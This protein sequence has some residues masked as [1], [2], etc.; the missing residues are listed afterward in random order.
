M[1][2]HGEASCL[3]R[4]LHA[5]V[6]VQRGHVPRRGGIDTAAETGAGGLLG[7]PFV[8]AETGI[9]DTAQVNQYLEAEARAVTQGGGDLDQV[10]GRHL[11]GHFT[12]IDIHGLQAVA[13]FLLQSFCQCIAVCHGCAPYRA[14]V[15][16]RLILFCNCMMPY[17]R[18]SAVGGQP[19]T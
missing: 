2:D 17:S 5:Q 11:D 7:Q 12:D 14:I 9:V 3:A 4:L 1:V 6:I 10:T 13:E 15:L 19:G 8:L 18:A 16:V